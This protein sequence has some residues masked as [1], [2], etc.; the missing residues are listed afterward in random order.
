M[1][2]KY[3]QQREEYILFKTLIASAAIGLALIGN[4]L[5]APPDWFPKD[6]KK[7]FEEIVVG[8]ANLG[9]SLNGYAA[10]YFKAFNEYAAELGVKPIMTDAALDPARQADQVR[11]LIAQQVDVM[12]V[13]PVNGKAIV[14]AARQIAQAGIPLIIS[15]SMIDESGMEAMTSYTGP[16]DYA[17]AQE[18]GKIMAAAL[19][20]KG[21]IVLLNGTPGY[22]MAQ[23][24]YDGFMEVISKYPDIKVLDS[25]PAD[26]SQAKGQT[27]MEN[28]ITRFGKQIDGVYSVDSGVGFGALTATRAAIQE[29][30][31]EAGKIKFVDATMYGFVWDLIKTGEYYGSVYQSPEEDAR[32]ALRSALKLAAGEKLKQFE[33]LETPGVTQANVDSIARPNF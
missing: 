20:G 5:A 21:N 27:L 24:R 11:D 17:E 8:F 10:A 23:L 28:F 3:V 31:L 2:R 30:T 33:Y 13:W 6:S 15:N 1:K 18:A 32:L 19:N 26:M 7:P 22:R 16:D 4:A 25:Q 29:G 14:P 12:I 9:P